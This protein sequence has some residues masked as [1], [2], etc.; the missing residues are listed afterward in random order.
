ME[1]NTELHNAV[2]KVADAASGRK[3]ETFSGFLANSLKPYGVTT[4]DQLSSCKHRMG[5]IQFVC[6]LEGE[7]HFGMASTIG[8]NVDWKAACEHIGVDVETTELLAIQI[9]SEFSSNL[10]SLI[11]AREEKEE[12]VVEAKEMA[13][14]DA[15]NL[16]Q[17]LRE[18]GER[19]FKC[20]YCD[21]VFSRDELIQVRECPIESCG[22][23]FFSGTDN[24]RNCEE[25]NRPFTRLAHNHGCPECEPDEEEC[26]EIS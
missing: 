7:A 16:I 23:E 24:G 9:C 17:E 12:K 15:E 4:F 11:K 19:I 3:L 1:Q 10:P 18:A 13:E 14:E 22:T 2:A 20:I 21:G 6:K 26:S 8:G 25:C 5:G